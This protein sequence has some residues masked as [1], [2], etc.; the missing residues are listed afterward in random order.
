MALVLTGVFL[1]W[2]LMHS[3]AQ[4][5][6]QASAMV[7]A[8][9]ELQTFTAKV[10]GAGSTTAPADVV[11]PP[12]PAEMD[13]PMPGAQS[14]QVDA[15]AVASLREAMQHGDARTPPL[16]PSAEREPP[17]AQ[18]LADPE[19]YAAYEQR[20]QMQVYQSFLQAANKQIANLEADIA[21]AQ[22]QGG[23]SDSQL[24]EG[25]RK[26]EALRAQ[27]DQVAAQYPDLGPQAEASSDSPA[28]NSP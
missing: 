11:A 12:Q 21:R 17:T 16:A 9:P 23:V 5:P 2:R 20:Q 25:E 8:T 14:W 26:L 1:G 6:V 19:L 4:P 10:H 22:Q 15:A 27:R 18:E 24:A 7:A 3:G 28:A 13:A